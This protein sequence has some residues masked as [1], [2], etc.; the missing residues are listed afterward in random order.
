MLPG[1]QAPTKA[2]LSLLSTAGQERENIT[3][4]SWV[5]IRTGRDPSSNTVLG[6]T[7]STYRYKVNLFITKS[8]QDNEK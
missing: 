5:E 4:G 1:L 2:A 3:K 8:E 7:G 6:I